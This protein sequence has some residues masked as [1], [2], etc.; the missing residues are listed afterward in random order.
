M[1][2]VQ[3]L[4]LLLHLLEAAVAREEDEGL[5]AVP[6][7]AV[8]DVRE[9]LEL[10]TQ[11]RKP[12]SRAL[13]VRLAHISPLLKTWQPVPSYRDRL[14]K[15]KLW[16]RVVAQERARE[17]VLQLRAVDHPDACVGTGGRRRGR[18]QPPAAVGD[19]RGGAT[20]G[21]YISPYNQEALQTVAQPGLQVR[22]QLIG[23]L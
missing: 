3:S 10:A 17:L 21:R 15:C 20:V 7:L 23:H 13:A 11:A 5:T 8:A 12:E 16:A 1:R 18:R 22:V 19:G 4:W 6:A 14:S 2:A 9:A